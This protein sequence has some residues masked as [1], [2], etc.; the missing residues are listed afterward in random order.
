MIFEYFCVVYITIY[1]SFNILKTLI[2]SRNTIYSKC[3]VWEEKSAEWNLERNQLNQKINELT[4]LL[5]DNELSVVQK[6][7]D[8]LQQKLQQTEAKLR[9]VE[10]TNIQ[11]IKKC[12]ELE[13]ETATA[14]QYEDLPDSTLKRRMAM[15]TLINYCNLNIQI[16]FF[17][18]QTVVQLLLKF[19]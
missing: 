13:K 6:P 11:L 19:L 15:V 14:S 12:A 2:E 4:G 8:N 9:S 7:I 18:S 5:V 17:C 3:K 1:F 16:I 10:D